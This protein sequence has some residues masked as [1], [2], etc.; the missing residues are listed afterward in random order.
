MSKT[1]QIIPNDAWPGAFY[2]IE[3]TL[4]FLLHPIID[5]P[6]PTSDDE[7]EAYILLGTQTMQSL[8]TALF[9]YCADTYAIRDH[10]KTLL[11]RDQHQAC[12]HVLLLLYAACREPVPA[13][14]VAVAGHEEMLT[15]FFRGVMQALDNWLGAQDELWR[16]EVR[17]AE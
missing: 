3:S 6:I 4:P 15:P 17:H 13:G 7:Q 5:V 8:L 1:E 2:G 9:R 11:E 12:H 16:R 10:L 14:M